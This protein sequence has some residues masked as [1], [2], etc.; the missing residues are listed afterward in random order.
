M[1]FNS[2]P[3]WDDF[4][5]SNGAKEQNYMRILFRPGFSVQARELTQVQSIIQNQ[6]KSF[7][8]NIF[9]DGT[10]V[11][12]GGMT[13]D[14]SVSSLTLNSTY[15]NEDIDL[16]NFDGNIVQSS[17]G[18]IKIAKVVAIS[19]SSS[20]PT[21]MIKYLRGNTTFQS[22]ES[23]ITPEGYSATVSSS[24]TGS[25]V[26]ISDG[27]FYK[28]GYF[29]NV[30]AQSLVLSTNNQSPS[31]RVGL[32]VHEM[33]IDESADSNLL[34]P[35]QESFNYQAPGAHRYQFN[36][37]L[38]KR[39]LDSQDDSRFFE[40]MR[41]V[42]GKVTRQF[43][44]TI[45]SDI[46]DNMAQRTED[47][48][49]DFVVNPFLIQEITANIS[50]PATANIAIS[51]GKAYVAGHMYQSS[52]TQIF[53]LDKA[54]TTISSTDYNLSL[55]YG[56][57]L[58]ANN[59]TSNSSGIFS[60]NQL[61]TI[62]LHCV[63]SANINVSSTDAYTRTYMG[64]AKVVNFS[65]NDGSEYEINLTDINLVQ[66]TITISSTSNT[67]NIAFPPTYSNLN[68]AYANVFIKVID[69]IGS[70]EVREIISYNGTTKI[71]ELDR[72]LIGALQVGNTI[73]LM[74]QPRNIDSLVIPN[75]GNTALLNSMDIA[76]DSRQGDY[77]LTYVTDT[78][79]NKLLFPLP[80]TSI[81][82]TFTGVNYNFRKSIPL[83]SVSSS[84]YTLTLPTGEFFYYGTDGSALSSTTA[85]RNFI[86][87]ATA[88]TG[89]GIVPGTVIKF[90]GSNTINR[91]SSTQMVLNFNS[92]SHVSAISI[93]AS[94]KANSSSN[95]LRTKTP[96]PTT[97][98]TSL[99]ATDSPSNADYNPVTGIKVDSANGFVWFSNP[100]TINKISNGSDILYI[101]DVYKLV[102]VYDS[103]DATTDVTVSNA[104]DITNNYYLDSGQTLSYYDHAK[105]VLKPGA[106]P[107]V[108]RIMA[109]V[110]YYSHDSTSG[111]FNSSSYPLS[112]YENGIIPIYIAPDN[113]HYNLRDCI[114]FRPTRTLGSSSSTFIGMKNPMCVTDTEMVLSYS[115]YV[116]RRDKVIL[117]SQR[118][119][120]LIEGIPGLNPLSPIIPSNSLELFELY[121]P[122]YT[123]NLSEIQ[124]TASKNK[125][126]TMKDIGVLEQRIENLEY[127]SALSQS[128]KNA[129][130]RT[131]IY[132]DGTQKEKYGI[133]TDN[134]EQGFNKVDLN[135]DYYA[136]IENGI[137]TAPAILNDIDLEVNQ[138]SSTIRI[139]DETISLPYTE[140]P[141]V[142][143]K[144]ATSNTPCNEYFW[145]KFIGTVDLY[146][147]S[148]QWFSDS[149]ASSYLGEITDPSII[150]GTVNYVYVSSAQVASA[151]P[152]SL[153]S[154]T[155][156][157]L[158]NSISLTPIQTKVTL[159]D[160]IISSTSS[161]ATVVGGKTIGGT[162]LVTPP[163]SIS[164]R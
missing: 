64:S 134:F 159:T 22:S 68:N 43:N 141:V 1:D 136:S 62:D 144:S 125:R 95:T 5:A 48:S 132:T 90:D 150:K 153:G 27:I 6:I 106:N 97:P 38:A 112:H 148:D 3:Y 123:F 37:V 16:T 108:G 42:D 116:P 157:Q 149:I 76:G 164:I 7:G 49:G 100:S 26:Y 54:R 57:L 143:Q 158:L 12:G 85:A 89:T 162:S 75:S 126:Y 44:T 56:N 101:P 121:I 58:Y 99:S 14:S 119:L 34:D 47:V 127:Y 82:R 81:S 93:V 74:Y 51:Q 107:P 86:V 114:D 66:N 41:I 29:V 52:N 10:V 2:E 145:G 151:T 24:N 130:N 53:S 98:V 39:A 115:Y 87:V 161:T 88:N 35:A 110:N 92:T 17:S 104:V 111:Y 124:I 140:T 80:Q 71:A 31:Y 122:A 84:T 133:F 60:I 15:N 135:S 113:N 79:L 142:S 8:D 23:I 32:E 118:G 120:L 13:L 9:Q 55:E 46:E 21:L 28:S 138:Y 19:P 91:V 25:V 117:N 36:L 33:I 4:E 137:M 160:P 72:N 83:A 109:I 156:F 69:G 139:G 105:L 11:S 73:S 18:F 94:V 131:L 147:A 96:L 163:N 128:E 70:G 40:L 77:N 152:Q 30:S 146:P 78:F 63:P 103:R 45:Y 67:S 20:S 102:A 61:P 129:T 65:H 59:Y 154:Y 155:P 50:N